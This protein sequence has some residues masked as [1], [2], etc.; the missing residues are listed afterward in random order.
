MVSL[1]RFFHSNEMG[2]SERSEDTTNK[3]GAQSRDRKERRKI[4]ET[5]IFIADADDIVKVNKAVCSPPFWDHNRASINFPDMCISAWFF[6]TPHLPCRYYS[7]I[8]VVVMRIHMTRK[9]FSIG[10]LL[11]PKVWGGG[12]KTRRGRRKW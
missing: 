4:N 12:R 11:N 2:G 1:H 3:K 10:G 6:P 9:E 5:R 8:T 7:N